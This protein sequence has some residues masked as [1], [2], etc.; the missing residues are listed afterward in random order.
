M[1]REEELEQ[2]IRDLVLVGNALVES[3]WGNG[4]SP[5]PEVCARLRELF[6]DPDVGPSH[7]DAIAQRAMALVER[8]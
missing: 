2:I 8:A 7:W 6:G 3:E 1:T 5:P 4:G